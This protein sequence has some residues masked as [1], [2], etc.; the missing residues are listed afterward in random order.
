LTGHSGWIGIQFGAA[1]EFD[2]AVGGVISS[3]VGGWFLNAP[4]QFLQVEGGAQC[5]NGLNNVRN[6]LKSK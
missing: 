6:L 5:G 4:R 2:G 1:I 3:C